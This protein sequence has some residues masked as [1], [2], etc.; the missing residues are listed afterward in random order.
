MTNA[1][2]Y[3]NKQLCD[4]EEPTDILE[5]QQKAKEKIIQRGDIIITKIAIL[6][7]GDY[8]K[9][10]FKTLYSHG[11][12]IDVFLD[13]DPQ[14]WGTRIEGIECIS[15]ESELIDKEQTLVIMAAEQFGQMQ[16]QLRKL[17][18]KNV[19]TKMQLDGILYNVPPGKDKF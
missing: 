7:A 15:V 5:S 3:V 6:G 12:N 8:G 18:F 17:Q 9:R 14:K 19:I 13:N 4:Y 10:V 11:I 2:D 1:F 16:Q